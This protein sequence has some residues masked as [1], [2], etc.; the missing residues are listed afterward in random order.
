M[1][2]MQAVEGHRASRRHESADGGEAAEGYVKEYTRHSNDV[3]LN[4]NE[5]RHR[6]ILTDATL[7]V[8][9]TRLRAHCAVLVACSGYFYT[10][11]VQRGQSPGPGEHGVSFSLPDGLDASS[12]S[13]LLDFMYTSRLP[14]S[15]RTVP[16][17]LAAATYLQMEHVADTCRTFMLNSERRP[18]APPL[19]ELSSM[20]PAVYRAPPGGAF[21]KYSPSSSSSNSSSSLLMFPHTSQP[22]AK[23]AEESHSMARVPGEQR[24]SVEQGT[25]LSQEPRSQSL[26]LEE[27][28]PVAPSPDSPSCSNGQPNSPAE[29]SSCNLSPKSRRASETKPIPDPKACNW[30]KYK[31]IVL[32]PLCATNIKEEET[33]VGPCGGS[34]SP[35]SEDRMDTTPKAT[36]DKWPKSEQEVI[37]RQGMV[38]LCCVPQLTPST[39]PV[40]GFLPCTLDPVLEHQA[41]LPQGNA[42]TCSP[43]LPPCPPE[44]ET[45]NQNGPS[46]CIHS[47]KRESHYSL[48]CYS[49]NLSVAKPS[50]TGDKPYRCNVCGAKFNRPA[51]LK[52]HSRIHSGEKPYHCDTCGA[53]FVQVAHL[54]AHVLI[55]TGEKPYPCHTCGTRFRHLQTLKSHLRIHTG[56]K[57]YSCEKC[58]LHFRHKSQLRLHLRQ[59]HGA[60]T[61]TKIRYKV[62]N[63]PYQSGLLQAC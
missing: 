42:A 33:G 49:G 29:S 62:L 13:L 30:K 21:S 36:N 57:P 26:K 4:L 58:D 54:R 61:N 22:A 14:L 3:L 51:N 43:Y 48:I 34:P 10:L 32:N 17:V 5:L 23:E 41:L 2:R 20:P 56:E 25:R 45:A 53:R 12:V 44:P 35:N 11:V 7:M 47:I 55:H 39:L 19:L 27:S 8:G 9:S 31:Y 6:D 38:A 52:T 40:P 60:I 18:A 24:A 59:K 1:S 63:D 16:G 46:P 37:D 15:P 50:S 28:E